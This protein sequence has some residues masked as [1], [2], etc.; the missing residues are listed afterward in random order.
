MKLA[1]ARARA[2]AYAGEGC[3][4][5]C[6]AGRALRGPARCPAGPL[7]PHPTLPSS[8]YFP[9]SMGHSF[10]VIA[11]TFDEQPLLSPFGSWCPKGGES[12]CVVA[13]CRAVVAGWRLDVL[14]WLPA[15]QLRVLVTATRHVCINN[16]DCNWCSSIAA[17]SLCST[18]RFDAQCHSSARQKSGC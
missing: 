14:W 9:V 3:R 2:H 6:P 15:L 17:F 18:A 1:A 11:N 13:P 4:G 5:S 16:Q 10:H 12:R 7:I 8:H